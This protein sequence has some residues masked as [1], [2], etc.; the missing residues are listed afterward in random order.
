LLNQSLTVK[1]ILLDTS[2]KRRA[3]EGSLVGGE[4]FLEMEIYLNFKETK[5][6]QIKTIFIFR[7]K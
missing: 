1:I 5:A 3:K 2:L 6:I 4:S 7:S